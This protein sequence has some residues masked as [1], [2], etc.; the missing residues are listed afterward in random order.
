MGDN[1]LFREFAAC[2][3]EGAFA[4]LVLQH[5]NLVFAT[6]YRQLG[7]QSLAEE[8]TQSVF[9]ALARKAGSLGRHPTVA[10]WLHKAT[11]LECRRVLRTE[12]RRQRCEQV[13]VTLGTV[14]AAGDSVWASLVPLLD[15]ALLEL[16]EK[17]RLAVLLRFL[18]ETPLREVGEALGA[19]EDAAQKRVA[20]ALSQMTDFF[21]QRGFAVPALTA[22]APLFAAAMQAAPAGLANTVVVAS[23]AG[24]TTSSTLTILSMWTN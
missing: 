13:A 24:A 15:D 23:L 6:A 21:R 1:S 2:R 14:N 19:S 17:D 12:L 9:V 7:N 20:R 4:A 18:E 3:S 5:V 11:L 16:N 10:G 22:S 8:V